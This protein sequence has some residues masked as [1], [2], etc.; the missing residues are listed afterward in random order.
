MSLIWRTALGI[1]VK[2]VSIGSFSGMWVKDPPTILVSSLRPFGRQ[3]FTC[4]HELGHW[5]FGH[6]LRVDLL[7]LRDI[8]QS[9]DQEELLANAYAG[10]LLMPVWAIKRA[11]QRRTW[12][13]DNCT[14]FQVYAIS[15]QFG[16]SYE[17]LATHMCYSV[18]LL[19]RKHLQRLLDESPSSIRNSL[20]PDFPSTRV[21][22]IDREWEVVPIDMLVGD[23]VLVWESVAASGT[24]IVS[25]DYPGNEVIYKAIS[26]GIVRL[27][28]AQ[29]NWSAYV[30][31]S[32]KDFEGR[33]IYRHM[34]VPEPDV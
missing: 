30:R 24:C 25:T 14:P 12:S 32:R 3:A 20:L 5:Y 15:C 4:A 16:V 31:V 8:W 29:N 22:I 33:A 11:F 27:H 2:F 10:F 18:N 7:E 34:E 21:I 6:G 19:S 28:D 1:E 23:H 9:N 13:I 17:A 26:P